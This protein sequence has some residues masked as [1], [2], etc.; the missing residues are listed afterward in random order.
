[1]I[2]T[3]KFKGKQIRII[4]EDDEIWFLLVDI[5][6]TLGLQRPG[7]IYKRQTGINH[8]NYRK[9]DVTIGSCIRPVIIVNRGGLLDLFNELSRQETQAFRTFLQKKGLI[10]EEDV[11]D[12]TTLRSE[13]SHYKKLY[14]QL[15]AW[16]KTCPL[17]PTET[18]SIEEKI[19]KELE[20]ID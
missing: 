4:P 8:D 10:I 15:M 2:K 17:H 14:N 12:I 6:K 19:I 5:S 7:D 3:Y 16:F 20:S 9:I 13:L 1:M 18:I 11:T